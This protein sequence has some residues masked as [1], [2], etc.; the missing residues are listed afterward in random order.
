[1]RAAKLGCGIDKRDEDG[2][3]GWLRQGRLAAKDGC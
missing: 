1:M 2:S 3:H